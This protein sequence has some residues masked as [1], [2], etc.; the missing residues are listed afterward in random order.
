MD[1]SQPQQPEGRA[2]VYPLRG[3]EGSRE[4][5]PLASD[6]GTRWMLDFSK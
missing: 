5:L 6:T 4:C 2:A 1:T 3:D